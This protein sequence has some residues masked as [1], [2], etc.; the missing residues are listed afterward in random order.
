M[1]VSTNQMNLIALNSIL[2][3]Q[4]KI[5]RSQEQLSTGKRI[6]SPSDDPSGTAALIGYQQT[7]DSLT[8][9][10]NNVTFAR[11]RL[12]GEES[13]LASVGNILDRVR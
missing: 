6:L 8:Q 5:A 4:T 10:Q 1:R 2:E 3:Q 11:Q 9:Y 13:A 7:L 12:Q